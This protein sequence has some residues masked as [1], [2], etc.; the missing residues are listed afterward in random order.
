MLQATPGFKLSLDPI[1]MLPAGKFLRALFAFVS[2]NFIDLYFADGTKGWPAIQVKVLN[3]LITAS[4]HMRNP[5]LATRHMTFLLQTMYNYMSPTERKEIALQLQ[6]V[7]Q[8]CEGA[9]VPLVS[10]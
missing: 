3:E 10:L 1:E 7:S 4:N 6:G 9:P 8:Q 5:A 2:N